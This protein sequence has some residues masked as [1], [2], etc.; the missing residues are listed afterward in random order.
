MEPFFS[1]YLMKGKTL[2]AH[3]SENVSLPMQSRK[4]SRR[5]L[6]VVTLPP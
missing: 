3:V 1:P 4:Y 5:F 2:L 6:L